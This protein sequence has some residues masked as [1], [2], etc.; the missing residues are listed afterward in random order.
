MKFTNLCEYV[1]AGLGLRPYENDE[2]YDEAFVNAI[3][4]YAIEYRGL[5]PIDL[6]YIFGVDPDLYE[7][8][9]DLLDSYMPFIYGSPNDEIV[10]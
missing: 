1:E 10:E 7:E 3:I 6:A 8:L 4:R 9:P 2:A 5:A